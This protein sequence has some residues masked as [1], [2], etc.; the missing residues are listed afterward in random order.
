MNS[1]Y[2]ISHCQFKALV[3]R[4]CTIILYRRDL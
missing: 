4:E 1:V 2:Q 3:A